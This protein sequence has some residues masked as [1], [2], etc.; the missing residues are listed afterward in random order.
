[1]FQDSKENDEKST[2]PNSSSAMISDVISVGSTVKVLVDYRPV[3]DDEIGVAKVLEFFCMAHF[4]L[5][6]YYYLDFFIS[7]L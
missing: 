2:T 5:F 6:L 1:M 7:F 3:R 4:H